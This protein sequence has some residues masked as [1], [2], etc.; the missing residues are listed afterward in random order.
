MGH[1]GCCRQCGILIWKNFRLRLRGWV[2]LLFELLLPPAFTLILVLI[3]NIVLIT[4]DLP[5]YNETTNHSLKADALLPLDVYYDPPTSALGFLADDATESYFF[6]FFENGG[7]NVYMIC[8]SSWVQNTSK[9]LVN[10]SLSGDVPTVLS[11]LQEAGEEFG[12]LNGTCQQLKTAI[13]PFNSTP[14][15]KAIADKFT[16]FLVDK[17]P[18]V[19]PEYLVSFD[20]SAA[21]DTYVVTPADAFMRF[22]VAL[23]RTTAP[24]PPCAMNPQVTCVPCFIATTK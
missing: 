7:A 17:F 5:A 21:L 11:I 19:K 10:A 24:S 14:A 18:V 23:L 16:S 6:E 4:V 13:L 1:S 12:S 9:A 15:A 2:A 3:R 20:S 8:D 22:E